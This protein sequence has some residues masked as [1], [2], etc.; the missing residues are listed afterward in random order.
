MTELRLFTAPFDGAL[1]VELEALVARVFGAFDGVDELR[2]KLERMPELALHAACDGDALVAF[3]LGYAATPVRYYS[4]LGGV[5]PRYRRQGIARR[6]MDAQH[7]WALA[8]GYRAIETGA[9]VDNAAMLMLNLQVGFRVIGMYQRTGTARA[10]LLK[11]LVL[12]A[13]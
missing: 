5:D 4:W 10:M 9:L 6:L 7:A 12:G 13:G 11:D 8:H 1:I 2:W 3:K